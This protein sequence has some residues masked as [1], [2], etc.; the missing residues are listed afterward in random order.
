MILSSKDRYAI[1]AMF[2]LTAERGARPIPLAELSQ[3]YDI[4]V[5]YLEQLF[6]QLRRAGLVQSRRGPTG[7]YLLGRDADNISIYDIVTAIRMDDE[8]NA[9]ITS[10]GAG[11]VMWNSLSTRVRK[12][13]TDI[14]LADMLSGSDL[15]EIGIGREVPAQ[16]ESVKLN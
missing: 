5:S 14:S 13:L 10:D 11:A 2:E 4:S 12:L 3:K 9:P 8:G 7:G 6:A 15:G 16:R 1:I